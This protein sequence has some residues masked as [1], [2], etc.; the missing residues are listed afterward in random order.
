MAGVLRE[1][2]GRLGEEGL[3]EGHLEMVLLVGR[4]G[5]LL[6]IVRHLVLRTADIPLCFHWG[7]KKSSIGILNV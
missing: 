7:R 4:R 2:V 3:Q 5:R 6:E 1:V